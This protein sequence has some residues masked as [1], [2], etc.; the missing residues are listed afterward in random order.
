MEARQLLLQRV[1]EQAKWPTG[2]SCP[3]PWPASAAAVAAVPSRVA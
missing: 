2:L 1:A 3:A